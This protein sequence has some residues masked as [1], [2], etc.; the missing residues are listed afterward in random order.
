MET[1]KEKIKDE[2]SLKDGTKNNEETVISL[3]KE[4]YEK[5]IKELKAKHIAEIKAILSKPLEYKEDAD[6]DEEDQ[7]ELIIKNLTKKIRDKLK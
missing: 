3:L 1:D 4:K 6:E 2:E 7:N 5:E